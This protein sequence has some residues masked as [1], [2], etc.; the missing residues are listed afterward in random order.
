MQEHYSQEDNN[1]ITLADTQPLMNTYPFEKVLIDSRY[2]SG[3]Y[4]VDSLQ[5]DLMNIGF[6]KGREPD[7]C[8][9]EYTEWKYD[10][11]VHN[12]YVI[13]RYTLF[14]KG[15]HIELFLVQIQR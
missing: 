8:K 2:F 4:R 12:V 9:G 15:L 3:K 5:G 7:L 1:E 10:D 14:V 11:E 6:Y 13:D